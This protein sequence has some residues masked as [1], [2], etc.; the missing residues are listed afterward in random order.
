MDIALRDPEYAIGLGRRRRRNTW[1]EVRAGH[2]AIERYA[3]ARLKLTQVDRECSKRVT[4][5]LADNH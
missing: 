3:L 1:G 2:A 4:D 5:L